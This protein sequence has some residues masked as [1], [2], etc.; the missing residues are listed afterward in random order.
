M[1][2]VGV[3]GTV[4]E[5]LGR[6]R[7]AGNPGAPGI[8]LQRGKEYFR[9]DVRGRAQLT[10]VSRA[11]ARRSSYDEGPEPGLPP[12][13]VARVRGR[14]AGHWRYAYRSRGR[15]LAQWS[16][17]CEMPTAF[18]VEGDTTRIVTGEDRLTGAPKS[19]A[20]GW[21]SQGEAFVILEIAYCGTTGDLPG[22]YRF[23]APGRGTLVFETK[24]DATAEMW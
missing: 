2:L 11:V 12:P 3:D 24:G 8:W 6:F 4:L 9:L 14:V 13:D 18:W 17:E 22:V 5:R 16:G 15:T 7:L 10:P 19:V 1:L 23:T 21:S 20:L